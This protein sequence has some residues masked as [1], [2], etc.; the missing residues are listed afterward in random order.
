MVVSDT[1]FIHIRSHS[2]NYFLIWCQFHATVRWIGQPPVFPILVLQKK[3][4][5][6]SCCLE[7]YWKK[8]ATISI[9]SRGSIIVPQNQFHIWHQFSLA[10]RWICQPQLPAIS[11]WKKQWQ[12]YLLP[13]NSIK[14]DSNNLC[15]QP[16]PFETTLKPNSYLT[17][18]SRF[19]PVILSNSTF[20]NV[21]L[22][23]AMANLL[24]K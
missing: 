23:L 10:A 21:S 5:K 19:D 14:I 12:I 22:T 8:A 6:S 13:E 2:Q 18:V 11:I 7:N 20:L 9:C 17:S 4:S 1:C 3:N 24:E 15:L 16:K